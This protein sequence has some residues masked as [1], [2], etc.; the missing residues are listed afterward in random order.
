LTEKQIIKYEGQEME[1]IL[2]IDFGTTNS[3]VAIFS[4]GMPETIPNEYGGQIIPS[5]VYIADNGDIYVGESAKNVAILHVGSTVLSV[6]REMGTGVKHFINGKNYTPEIIASFIFKTLKKTAE[7]KIGSRIKKAVVTVPAYYD[8]KK[9]QDTKKAAQLAG[10]EVVRIVNEP[11]AAAMAYGIKSGREGRVLVFDLG[12]GTFDVSILNVEGGVFEVLATRG[13]ARLGGDDF[14]RKIVEILVER[15]KDETK[16]DLR[17][18]KFALQKVYEE[19]EKAK[20][21]LSDQKIVEI[22]IPFIAAD[23]SGPMHLITK[24]TRYEFEELI[25]GYIEK[26]LRLTKT[27]LRDAKL[28][29]EDID[30]VLLVGGSTRIPIVRKDLKNLFKKEPEGSVSP[31]EIV[32]LGAAVQGAVMS[33]RIR[34]VALVDVTPLGLG[35]EK[36]GGV[37]VKI[38][39]RNTVLPTEASAI[40]T[41]VQDYQKA[42]I[43]HVLQGERPNASD[44]IS[45][46][47]FRLG[48]IRKDLKGVPKI[49]VKFEIDVS[50]IVRVS[51]KDLDTL[52]E[53]TVKLDQAS[54]ISE[55]EVSEV[56]TDARASELE[57]LHFLED[58]K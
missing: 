15:F 22:E 23:E 4:K 58:K 35:V 47:S 41:T 33:G 7:H 28:N 53:Y 36:E 3:A 50:G 57:D 11:T 40:F 17:E 10:L 2:G 5:A 20:K 52:C 49:E 26:T 55:E 13:D 29:P 43:I 24:F 14:D 18:D 39:K 9:R 25:T 32:A 56:I 45:L 37:M 16:I 1:S 54:A 46:G 38:I 27:A 31:D 19:A 48:G 21:A 30:R 12:G 34:K 51:A 6:K 8:D 42:V 44:N